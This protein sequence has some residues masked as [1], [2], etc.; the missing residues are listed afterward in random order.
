MLR[1]SGC[2]R[3]PRRQLPR[4]GIWCHGQLT[5]RSLKTISLPTVLPY[6]YLYFLD[7][8]WLGHNLTRKLSNNRN[9]VFS[10]RHASS[11]QIGRGRE[12]RRKQA[13]STTHVAAG[14]VARDLSP[15][16][17]IC[18]RQPASQ[19]QVRPTADRTQN[20]PITHQAGPK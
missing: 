9:P 8:W 20:M 5:Y 1:I 2:F 14:A 16:C 15:P 4:L 6:S 12:A 19:A 3:L 7:V 10:G 13:V 18:M 17:R 11:C